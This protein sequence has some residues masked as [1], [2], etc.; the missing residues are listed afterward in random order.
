MIK[1]TVLLEERLKVREIIVKITF[2]KI[3][4][5]EFPRGPVVRTL[6]FH[7]W[8]GAWG[9]GEVVRSL[10]GGRRSCKEQSKVQKKKKR[11]RFMR[12]NL[13]S[14]R[15]NRSM[16]KKEYTRQSQQD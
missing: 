1:P 11:G 14:E 5:R 16:G 9:R 3:R 15:K 2:I 13:N 4:K 10:V 12:A 6:S 7:C 8:G